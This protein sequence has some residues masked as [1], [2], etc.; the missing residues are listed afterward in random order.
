MTHDLLTTQ[1]LATPPVPETVWHALAVA[2]DWPGLLAATSAPQPPALVLGAAL[3]HARAL[4]VLNQGDTANQAL[5]VAAK[6]PYEATAT[7]AAEFVE[8]LIQC[9]HYDTAVQMTARLQNA[10][11]VQADYLWAMLWRER[12]DWA[13]CDAALARLKS[14]GPP[15]LDLAQ[16][17]EAWALLRQGR[18][19]MAAQLLALWTQHANPGVQKLL[20]RLELGRGQHQAAAQR[21]EAVARQQP[22]DWEWPP[23]LA[24][25]LAPQLAQNNPQQLLQL[26][27][28]GLQRQP[29]QAEAL[30][31]R[32][33]LLLALG[34]RQQAEADTQAA[35]AIKHWLDAPVLLWVEDALGQRDYVRAQNCLSLARRQLDTPKRASAALDLLRFQGKK[36]NEI[37]VAVDALQRQ[38]PRDVHALRTA[39]AALQSV[40][41]FDPAARCYAQALAL[42]PDDGATRNNLALLYRDRGDLEEAIAT[43]RA[44]LSEADDTVRLNYAHTLLLRGDRRE[45]ASIFRDVLTRQPHQSAALRG[46]ADVAYA[47]GEDAL[48]W[49]Y[50]RQSLEVDPKHPLAWKVA[51]GIARRLEGEA[52]AIALL[53]QA[54]GH[55]QPVL[56]VRQALFQRWR[57][58]LAAAELRQRLLAWCAAEPGEVDYWLM[59]ADAAHD[60]N[61]FEGCEQL[62]REAYAREPGQGGMPLLRFYLGRE[63]EGAARRVAEQL[64]KDDPASMRH[65]GLLAEVLYRQGRVDEALAALEAGLKR[66]PSRLSLVQQKVGILLVQERFDEAVAAARALVATEALPP[67]L[68]LLSEALQRVQRHDEAVVVL[69]Q[70][71]LRAPQ[72]RAL[73][74]MHASA[75]RRAGQHDE[76]LA[77]LAQLYTDEP[78]NFEVVRRY[79][80][81]LTVAERL[82][83]AVQVL[84]QLIEHSGQQPDLL[85]AVADLQRE[86]GFLDEA[87]AVINTALSTHPAH[88]GLWQQCAAIEKRAGDVAAESAAWH[89]ILQRFPARRWAGSG[90]SSLVR[91]GLIEPMQMA[92]NAW[93][94]A[95]PANVQPWWAAFRAAHEMKQN[96]LALSLLDKIEQK[97]GPQAEVH[98]ARANLLQEAWSMSQAQQEIK[99]AIALRPDSISYRETLFNILVK[100]G[101]FEEIDALMARLEHLLGDRRY[102]RYQG[103]FFNINCHPTWSAAEVWRFYEDWYERAIKPNLPRAK[104]FTNQPDPARKLRIGYLSPDFHRHAVAYFSEPLLVEHDREQFELYA[105]AH[106]DAGQADGYTERFKTYFDH[107]TETRGMSDDELERKIRED[108]IDILVDLAGHTSN[109]R[110]SLML[111]RPAP[112]QA[113]WIWGAGQTT[114][115]P[116]VDYF[117]TDSA[118]VP[119]EHDAYMAEKVARMSRPGLPFKPAHDVL[120]PTPLPCLTNGFITLGVLARPLRTNRATVALWAKILQRVPTSILRFDHVPYAEADVQQRLIGYFAEH[121]VGPERLQFK[122]TRPHWQVYQEIDLQLDP[123]P[124]GSGTTASEGLYMERLVVTLKSRP[125][126]GLMPHGQLEAV[127]LERLCTGDTEEAY[128]E[129]T[130]ALVADF[131]RLAELS[132]GLRERVKNSWLMDYAGYGRE[133]ARMYRQMWGDWCAN[134]DQGNL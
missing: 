130:V 116:Q 2:Q 70:S 51:A 110:L 28:Q 95:E 133:A 86:Q 92:L 61:D 27:A 45:A 108:R 76:A 129:K 109:N 52:R 14:H 55:A 75:L 71:L 60:A 44:A 62:L 120:E 98:E 103:F 24:A 97:R 105:Y 16:L 107:W 12:E 39:G 78:T 123:F 1:S 4:R 91:L 31:N 87:R 102:A 38:F 73:R 33:R 47:A 79:V 34:Q 90:V 101:D 89:Q 21:L 41:L 132:A 72:D 125:P 88:L 19:G 114:G 9:A 6:S 13:Q 59:A 122:N 63:R 93:R 5:L 25:A 118:S 7:Q 96:N 68:A 57:G 104:P 85:S 124:A 127:G 18:L 81:Q 42:A 46:M 82:P 23:L 35:L 37:Q 8:E 54:E 131:Q 117:L 99:Q 30:V 69:A 65:W 20:A 77:A 22:L 84:R 32:A 115:L 74:L 53:Q 15:W 50:A 126:M 113:S 112:V 121:G 80:L 94:E 48:A 49:D 111:R 10:G 56:P 26:Y 64:V 119:P 83:E 67:Q 134:K 3:W 58:V 17:Q 100:A 36:R 128:L 66:E 43:W 29:R 11:A 106:L 40:K